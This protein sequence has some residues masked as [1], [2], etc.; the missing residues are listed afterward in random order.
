VFP[1]V[2]LV[3][4]GEIPIA[5]RSRYHRRLINF[6]LKLYDHLC[7]FRVLKELNDLMPVRILLY[8]TSVAEIGGKGSL[9]N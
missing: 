6:V 2:G 9:N 4:I 5:A 8:I 3:A 7:L 1:I